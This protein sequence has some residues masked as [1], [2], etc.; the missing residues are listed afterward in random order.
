VENILSVVS[1]D[2]TPKCVRHCG[3]IH[4]PAMKGINIHKLHLNVSQ[5]SSHWRRLF[6][7]FDEAS[8][9]KVCI[10]FGF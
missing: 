9:L 7:G 8:Q 10:V 5:Y 2:A 3:S 6:A 4:E 1:E